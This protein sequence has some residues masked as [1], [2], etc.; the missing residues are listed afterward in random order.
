MTKEEKF[1]AIN[2]RLGNIFTE[3]GELSVMIVLGCLEHLKDLGILIDGQY[4]TTVSG[5][6]ILGMCQEFDWQPTNEEIVSICHHMCGEEFL[7]MA[8]LVFMMLN[9][10][11]K[12]DEVS[13]KIKQKLKEEGYEEGDEWK[14]AD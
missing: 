12:F 5:A 13:E 1:T 3:E 6:K 4:K 8:S 9:D 7:D 2:S 14:N 11:V 10:R